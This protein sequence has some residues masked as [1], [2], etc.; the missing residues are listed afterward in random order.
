M[1]RKSDA[2]IY[3]T[4]IVFAFLAAGGFLLMSDKIGTLSTDLKNVQLQLEFANRG[5]GASQQTGA[6]SSNNN[7]DTNQKQTETAVQNQ[8]PSASTAIPAAILFD[9]QSSPTLLPQ[10]KLT[11]TIENVDRTADGTM[12]V[13]L[14]VF[15]KEAKGYSAFDPKTVIE[16]LNLNGDNIKASGTNGQFASMPPKSAM[17]GNIIFSTDPSRSTVIIQIGSDDSLKFYEFN[18]TKKTYKETTVG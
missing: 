17:T 10:T 9:T 14:K 6:N 3:I 15:T 2:P 8:Q 11:V 4:I 5:S 13:G 12:T 7:L 16:I 18:F 1:E